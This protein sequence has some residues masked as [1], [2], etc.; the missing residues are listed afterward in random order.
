MSSTGRGGI[1]IDQDKYYTPRWCIEKLVERIDFTTVRSFMEPCAGDGRI[2]DYIPNGI[3]K[4]SCELDRGVDYLTHLVQYK[5]DLI[6]TNPPFS[7][8]IEFLTKSLN[9]A[10]TVCYLQRLN[11]LGSK[12]RK[13]FW[14]NNTPDKLFILAQR[15]QFMKEMGLKSGSDSTEY[16][17]FIWDKLNIVKGKHIEII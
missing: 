17:W 11:W 16:A 10:L 4:W 3:V 13:D 6:I 12:T 2:N 1:K 8:S 15:P 7:K 9:E 14:N 5:D